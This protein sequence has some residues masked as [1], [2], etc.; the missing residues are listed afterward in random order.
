MQLGENDMKEEN[1]VKLA[2]IIKRYIDKIWQTDYGFLTFSNRENDTTLEVYPAAEDAS[3]RD[4]HCHV[5]LIHNFQID[6]DLGVTSRPI[7][8]TYENLA[9]YIDKY[10]LLLIENDV[11][12]RFGIPVGGI[13]SIIS[14]SDDGLDDADMQL[15]MLSDTSGKLN[16]SNYNYIMDVKGDCD[17]IDWDVMKMVAGLDAKLHKAHSVSM[18]CVGADTAMHITDGN[19]LN[20]V[21][22]VVFYGKDT[23]NHLQ[24]IIRLAEANKVICAVGNNTIVTRMYTVCEFAKM[25]GYYV[26]HSKTEGD[27]YGNQHK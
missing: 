23:N 5:H 20:G 10:S 15:S 14:F 3:I 21:V 7:L 24:S 9:K 18:Y 13:N 12:D 6:V 27:G 25:Q 1:K 4:G 16:F 8:I 2:K 11:T 26:S 19:D 17:D 22:N